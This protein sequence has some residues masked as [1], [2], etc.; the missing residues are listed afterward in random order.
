MQAL[1][2]M[3]PTN[4]A[5]V[6]NAGTNQTVIWPAPAALSGTIS[7][8]GK[9]NPPGTVAVTWSQLSSPG[10]VT[11]AN[12]NVLATTASFSA[13]G[14]YVLQLAANDGQVMTVGN[15]TV[16]A[17]TRPTI[18]FQLLADGLQLSWQTSG[19]NWLLQCQTNPPS[20]GLGNDWVDVSGTTT[21]PFVIPFD[22]TAG[23]VFY[24]LLLTN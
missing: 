9:P 17:I 12:S 19:G 13:A 15:V 18:S 3:P 8:D 14:A 22:P 11:F 16:T 1:A 21:N 2:S 23:L 20:V 10:T 6:V 5:P 7:D 24:R 4:V